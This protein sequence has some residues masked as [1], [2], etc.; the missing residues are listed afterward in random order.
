M[1]RNIKRKWKIRYSINFL[2]HQ[3]EHV[4]KQ[5]S[6]TRHYFTYLLFIQ[7]FLVTTTTMQGVLFY[8]YIIN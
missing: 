3:K 7:G 1:I 2:A 6:F 5:N 8:Q 4:N